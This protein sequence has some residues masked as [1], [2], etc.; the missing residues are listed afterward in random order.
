MPT[1]MLAEHPCLPWVSDPDELTAEAI[2]SM[3]AWSFWWDDERNLVMLTGED[4]W[5]S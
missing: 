5:E 3:A 4:Q 1:F 2:E